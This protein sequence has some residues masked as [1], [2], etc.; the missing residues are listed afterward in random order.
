VALATVAAARATVAASSERCSADEEQPCGQVSAVAACGLAGACWL[1][2]AAL[3][4][5]AAYAESSRGRGPLPWL[6]ASRVAGVYGT[7]A[8]AGLAVVVWLW[9]VL[10]RSPLLWLLAF[11]AEAPAEALG[12][13]HGP[14]ATALVPSFH[15]AAT[16]AAWGACIAAFVHAVAFT[17]TAP[18]SGTVGEHSAR[19]ALP[20]TVA[21]K[22]FHGLVVVLFSPVAASDPCLLA[23]AFAVALALLALLE[24][25]RAAGG[26]RGLPPLGEPL[27]RYYGRFVDG[28][29]GA[30]EGARE[31]SSEGSRGS[32][33]A[34]APQRAPQLVLTPLY[35]L[36]GC[37]VPHWAALAMAVGA[38]GGTGGT[39]GT[40]GTSG[41]SGA[42]GRQP[43]ELVV[44]LAGVVALGVGDAAAAVV[45]RRVGRT[46]WPG[47]GQRTVEGSAAALAAMLI[48][49]T[50]AGSAAAPGSQGPIAVAAALLPALVPAL[51]LV[52]LVEAYATAIDNLVLPLYAT[53]LLTVALL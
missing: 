26:A 31:G 40:S 50:A 13:R 37:A 35:L 9:V 28:R 6:P 46:Q 36:A 4:V 51:A 15:R 43:A 53:A 34:G 19:C 44:R 32:P 38:G 21:R 25:C 52:A 11:L 12:P 49:A 20:K 16:L 7:M 42:M 23:L 27:R 2:T 47:G 5:D 48:A 10:R 24:V 18:A 22:L 39:S 45:G 29:E 8:A 17:A 3:A 1:V 30:R 14:G 41:A 33:D